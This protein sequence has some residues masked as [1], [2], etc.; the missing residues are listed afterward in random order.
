MTTEQFKR[1]YAQSF[2]NRSLEMV[3]GETEGWAYLV[4]NGVKCFSESEIEAELEKI[5]RTD[6]WS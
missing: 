3:T 4:I 5:E 6:G 2:K 1:M